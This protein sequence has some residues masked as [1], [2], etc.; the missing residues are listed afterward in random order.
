VWIVERK[1]QKAG[2][3]EINIMKD[4]TL[5]IEAYVGGAFITKIKFK[6]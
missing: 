2:T 4:K 1:F 6:I 3:Q 5:F